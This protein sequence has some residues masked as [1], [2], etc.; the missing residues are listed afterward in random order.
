M[1]GGGLRPRALR[2][3]PHLGANL[4]DCPRWRCRKLAIRTLWIPRQPALQDAGPG[5]G[6]PSWVR[7]GQAARRAPCPP[8]PHQPLPSARD[9][10]GWRGQR[11]WQPQQGCKPRRRRRRHVAAGQQVQHRG[12]PAGHRRTAGH[13]R[14]AGGSGERCGGVLHGRR[15]PR[16]THSRTAAN[17]PS[18]VPPPQPCIARNRR[19]PP[20]PDAPGCGAAPPVQVTALGVSSVGKWLSSGG[21]TALQVGGKRRGHRRP[22]ACALSSSRPPGGR[23]GRQRTATC[24]RC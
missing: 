3:R 2:P 14:Q 12:R 18:P 7:W 15:L 22:G 6:E 8:A 19:H 13:R 21:P 20:A 17:N 9:G 10:P 4:A 24:P 23:L 16:R 1:P 5:G 11:G